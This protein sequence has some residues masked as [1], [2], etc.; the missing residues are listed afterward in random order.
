MTVIVENE[1]SHEFSLEQ[2]NMVHKII[3][4]ALKMESYNSEAEISVTIVTNEKIQELNNTFRDKNS[5]TD[6]LSFPQIDFALGES[7]PEKGEYLL[8]DIVFSFDK[9]I[10]QA[11]EYGHNLDREIGFFI[12]HSMLHLMG[13]DHQDDDSEQI[14]FEKQEKILNMIGLIR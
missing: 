10:Q 2:E 1:S 3:E 12:A 9:A 4:E 5:V 7:A 13:Y 6:V 14:M 11:E 8:G